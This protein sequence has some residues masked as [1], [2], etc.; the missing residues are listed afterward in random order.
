MF[1]FFRSNNNPA[2]ITAQEL[3]RRQTAGEPLYMVDVREPNEYS[4]GHIAGTK[5]IPLGQLAQHIDELPRDKPIVVICRSGG[6]SRVAAGQ[7]LQA[8][9][10]QVLN[11]QGGMN[12]WEQGRLPVKRGG[13]R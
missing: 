4:A 7:L 1:Q 12:A 3:Q 10:T 9:L 2:D 11:L 5:L 8:G 13:A 6:R